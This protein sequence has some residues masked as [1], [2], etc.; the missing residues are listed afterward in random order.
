[1]NDAALDLSAMINPLEGFHFMLRVEAV[2][3]LPCKSIK[4]FTKENEYEYIQEGG[5]NDYVHMRRKPVSKPFTFEV[6]RY[7]AVDY[8]DPLPNGAELILPVILFVSHEG[9]DFLDAVSRTYTF[10]GCTVTGKQY[11]QLDAESSGLLL[12]TTTIAYRELVVV[13]VPRTRSEP[14]GIGGLYE[15]PKRRREIK[16]MKKSVVMWKPGSEKSVE[17]AAHPP[18]TMVKMRN[19]RAKRIES[20]K[21]ETISWKPEEIPPVELAAHTKSGKTAIRQ[22]KPTRNA[23]DITSVGGGEK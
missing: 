5:L 2:F 16:N 22:W 23:S 20:T 18:S 1:M 4:G 3:D 14:A 7:V 6:E 8:L 11:G 17:S 12:E 13:D 19:W 15:L 10:T 21:K 9:A